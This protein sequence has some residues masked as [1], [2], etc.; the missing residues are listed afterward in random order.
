MGKKRRGEVLLKSKRHIKD[1]KYI[2]LFLVFSVLRKKRF[3]VNVAVFQQLLRIGLFSFL[4]GALLKLLLNF[5]S[6]APSPM[7]LEKTTQDCVS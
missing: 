1:P 3:G 5:F 2:D 4:T 7:P 6:L